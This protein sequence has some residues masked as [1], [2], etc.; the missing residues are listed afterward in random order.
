MT[1]NFWKLESDKPVPLLVHIHGGGWIGGKKN[2]TVS[3]NELKKD[4]ALPPLII[5]LPA[6]RSYPQ[7]FTMLLVHSI[8]VAPS[9]EWNFNPAVSP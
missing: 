5:D 9:K 3:P 8:F 2:E 1:L 4:T 7:L 6:R